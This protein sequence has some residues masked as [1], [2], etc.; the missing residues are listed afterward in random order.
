MEIKGGIRLL[1][2]GRIRTGCLLMGILVLGGG[3]VRVSGC[4]GRHAGG[5]ETECMTEDASL[6]W[7]EEKYRCLEEEETRMEAELQE[8][9]ETLPETE[10]LREALRQIRVQ[11]QV[12]KARLEER[13]EEE[14]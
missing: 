3:V 10:E 14:E 11:K 6:K 1:S 2:A 12:L 13:G 4:A 9:E 5:T 8:M 7:M